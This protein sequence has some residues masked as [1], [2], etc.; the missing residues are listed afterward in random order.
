MCADLAPRMCL[1]CAQTLTLSSG[2][3]RGYTAVLLWSVCATVASTGSALC[4]THTTE[5]ELVL[6]FTIA[7]CVL[8]LRVKHVSGKG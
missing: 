2:S 6:R 7:L 4:Q 1:G 5:V 8:C 3:L